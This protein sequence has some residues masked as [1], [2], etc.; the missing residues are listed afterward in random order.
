M[1]LSAILTI[2][3]E[4]NP[5]GDYLKLFEPLF[6]LPRMRMSH[7]HM[8]RTVLQR[9]PLMAVKTDRIMRVAVE[10]KL[11]DAC[12]IPHPCGFVHQLLSLKGCQNALY[13]GYGV[14]FLILRGQSRMNLRGAQWFAGL[15][16]N[17]IYSLTLLCPFDFRREIFRGF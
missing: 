15:I 1:V 12:T 14:D 2:T 9:Y 17:F 3:V 7:S 6:F 11:I 10:A 16:Q 5:V 13:G 8:Q 4:F